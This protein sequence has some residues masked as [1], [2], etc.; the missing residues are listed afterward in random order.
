MRHDIRLKT[1]GNVTKYLNWHCGTPGNKTRQD[2]YICHRDDQ[3]LFDILGKNFYGF[4]RK[5]VD[6]YA[7]GLNVAGVDRTVV[8]RYEKELRERGEKVEKQLDRW[9][10]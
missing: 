6:G 10:G 2:P 7:A 5:R 3:S 4:D 9:S 1:I 8:R